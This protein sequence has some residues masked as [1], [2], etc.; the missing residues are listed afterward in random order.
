MHYSGEKK[1]IRLR[2]ICF[3]GIGTRTLE[4]VST[5]TLLSTSIFSKKRIFNAA[6]CRF[7]TEPTQTVPLVTQK[8]LY[9]AGFEVVRRD[10]PVNGRC[11]G[12]V[13]IYL[14]NN[15][16]YHIRLDLSDNQLECLV[17]EITRPHSRPFLVSTWYRP[18][19]SSQDIFSRFEILVDKIDSENNDFYLLGDLNCDMLHNRSNYHISSNL[20]NIFDIYGLSQMISE[21]TRIT[22]T[23][24]TLIDL[25]ITNSPE[26]IVN[27]GVVHLGI[28]DHSQVFMTI[29]VRYERVGTHRIIETRDYKHKF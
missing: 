23:S 29:K 14:R 7:K 16:N 28:S 3:Q 10:R 2:K 1:N 15:I 18:P 22:S 27:S 17:I 6:L 13:C 5:K 12:G 21:P 19:S 8:Y 4:S 26:K 25:C 20:T 24:R 9:H 11:G